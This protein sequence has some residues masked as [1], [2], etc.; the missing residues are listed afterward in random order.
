MP[1]SIQA[2]ASDI[3]MVGSMNDLDLAKM[4]QDRWPGVGLVI[5]MIRLMVAP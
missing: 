4:V 1:R 5:S 2:A 3:E